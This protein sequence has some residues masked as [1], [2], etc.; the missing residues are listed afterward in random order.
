[1]DPVLWRAP[2]MRA[3]LARRDIARV[4]QLL[5]RRGVTQ[6]NIALLTQQSP[7]EVSEILAGRQVTSYDVL[8]RIADGLG[9]P[10]GYLGLAYAEDDDLAPPRVTSPPGPGAGEVEDDDMQRRRF[11]SLALGFAA[12]VGI[13]ASTGTALATPTSETPVPNRV[14]R[15]E[16]EQL[17]STARMLAALD[18]QYGART[19]RDAVLA[20]MH[21]AERLLEAA[22]GEEV[23]R[24]LL[25]VLTDLRNLAGW[26]SHDLGLNR[27]AH[28]LLTEALA[29]ARA[30]GDPVRAVSALNHIGCVHLGEAAP[31][32]ALKYFQL[33]H[34]PASESRSGRASALLWGHQ[35]KAYADM[36]MPRAA[37]DALARA[38]AA[39]HGRD[40]DSDRPGP[41]LLDASGLDNLAGRV[42]AMLALHDRRYATHAVERL[43]RSASQ[44]QQT[45]TRRRVLTLNRLAI[46]HLRLGD[47]GYG[48][49]VGN[50]VADLVPD[51][52][53]ERVTRKI[54]ALRTE[55]LRHHKSRDAMELAQRISDLLEP[56]A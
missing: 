7:S 56:A 4:Y 22:R 45:R 30:A 41:P 6:R 29:S 28:G 24:G 47:T 27:E 48:V 38:E 19:I 34:L 42:Y 31:N 2:E 16:L 44:D 8:I 51:V 26:T 53:S 3:A 12:G 23:E 18:K 39:F 10:R 37:V 54:G 55:A 49:R 33:G 14:G 17:R 32:E 35:A 13:D 21:Y 1:M 25:A 20:A 5:Q 50:E 46:T 11:F 52:R 15:A 40:R 36:A 9:V 43:M